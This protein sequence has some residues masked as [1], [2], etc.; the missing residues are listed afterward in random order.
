MCRC[1]KRTKG[2]L[3]VRDKV[4]SVFSSEMHCVDESN[5]KFLS[6]QNQW[7]SYVMWFTLNLSNNMLISY[8]DILSGI[9]CKIIMFI[10]L[11]HLS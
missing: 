8:F 11:R 4:S 2:E 1:R 3:N 10:K 9:L 6:N 5:N 7:L